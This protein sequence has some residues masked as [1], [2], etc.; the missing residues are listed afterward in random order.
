MNTCL[1]VRHHNS[2][3]GGPPDSKDLWSPACLGEA[4]EARRR[5]GSAGFSL[6]VLS[7]LKNLSEPASSSACIPMNVGEARMNTEYLIWK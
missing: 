3:G 7:T 2:P 1:R 5:A 4:S 6:S